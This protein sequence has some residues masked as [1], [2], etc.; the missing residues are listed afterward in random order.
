MNFL[1]VECD[2]KEFADEFAEETL[3]S[4]IYIQFVR[5]VEADKLE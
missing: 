4:G 1:I 5:D 2:D 3:F